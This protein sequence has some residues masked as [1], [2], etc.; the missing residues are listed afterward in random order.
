MAL[1]GLQ[2]AN[3]GPIRK[4]A[5]AVD[6]SLRTI[7]GTIAADANLLIVHHGLFW[8][9]VQRLVGHRYERLRHLLEHDVAVYST[10][11]PLDRHPTLGNNALL[12]RALGLE[13]TGEFARHE[14]ISIG[15]R[16][17]DTR[18]TAEIVDAAR[19]FARQYGG[20]THTSD[21]SAIAP[22]RVTRRWGICS[23]AGASAETLDEATA[24]GLDTLIV[25]EGPHWTAVEAPELGLVIIYAG[26]Y[27]TET[28]G[29]RALGEHVSQTFGIPWTFVD[30][31]TGT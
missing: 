16:G 9:G 6:G 11:L 19:A 15:V 25:G 18:P 17:E 28:L 13:P 27:A 7:K 10:H 26:H 20:H 12:A 21:T 14:S 4:I 8:G 29:V 1:N 22:G 31:P 24:L 23:G 3:R 5:T 30:A 2:V